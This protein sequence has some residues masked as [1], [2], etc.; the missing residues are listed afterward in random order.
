MSALRPKVKR[1]ETK[2]GQLYTSASTSYAAERETSRVVKKRSKR[3]FLRSAGGVVLVN[4]RRRRVMAYV[5]V[6]DWKTNQVC[7]WLK[8]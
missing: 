8:G 2:R 1:R 3:K 7:E 5:N 4:E 6:A